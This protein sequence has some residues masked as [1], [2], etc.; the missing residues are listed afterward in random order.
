MKK[1]REISYRKILLNIVFLLAMVVSFLYLILYQYFEQQTLANTVEKAVSE[2]SYINQN[3]EYMNNTVIDMGC[4]LFI[5]EELR[6]L[7][8]EKVSNREVNNGIHRLKDPS[9]IAIYPFGLFV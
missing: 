4:G 3:M 7:L 6:P 5:E 1:N 9:G 8:Y 2:L